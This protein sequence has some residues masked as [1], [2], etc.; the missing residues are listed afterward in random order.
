MA[1]PRSWLPNRL[2]EGDEVIGKPVNTHSYQSAERRF[3][4]YFECYNA[5]NGQEGFKRIYVQ[6]LYTGYEHADKATLARDATEFT[7][8]ELNAYKFLT[9]NHSKNTPILLAYKRGIQP[10]EGLI[11]SRYIRW[12]VWEKVPRTYLGCPKSA[13]MY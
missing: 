7:P 1:I 2:N 11:P 3:N 9:A 10:T 13:F 12:I 5:T 6:V 4:S 8:T